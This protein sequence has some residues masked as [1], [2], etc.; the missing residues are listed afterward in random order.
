MLI[1]SL[2]N[3]N[4]QMLIINVLNV[5]FEKISRPYL[6]QNT[7]IQKNRRCSFG[8]FYTLS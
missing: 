4:K 1:I 7:K 2:E 5:F 8:I 3:M 6:Q